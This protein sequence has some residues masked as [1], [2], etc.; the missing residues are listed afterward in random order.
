MD[1]NR[2]TKIPSNFLS[3]GNFESSAAYIVKRQNEKTIYVFGIV[4]LPFTWANYGTFGIKNINFET[5]SAFFYNLT[6]N[7]LIIPTINSEDKLFNIQ[8]EADDVI[9]F[10]GMLFS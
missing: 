5:S 6:R 4:K 7:G 10:Y 1:E 8:A 3:D 9:I 2:Q